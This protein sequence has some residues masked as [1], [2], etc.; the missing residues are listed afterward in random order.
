MKKLICI[1]C[2]NGCELTVSGDMGSLKVNGNLCARGEAFAAAELTHPTRSL[3]TTV[4]TSFC[5]VPVL[6]VRTNGEIPKE[7]IGLAM[8]QLGKI[9]VRKPVA[10]GEEVLEDVAK[11]GVSVIATSSILKELKL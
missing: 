7:L 2:P 3:T 1:V 11:S 10:C 4:R 5:Q 9:V 8:E 6:P